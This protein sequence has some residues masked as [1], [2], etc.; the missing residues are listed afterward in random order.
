VLNRI[1]KPT[2]ALRQARQAWRPSAPRFTPEEVAAVLKQ[3]AFT[4]QAA[5]R[6]LTGGNSSNIALE[7]TA[8]RVVLKRYIWPWPHAITEHTV[9]QRARERQLPVP[10]LH[11]NQAGHTYTTVNGKTY[12]VFDFVDGFALSNFWLWP[13]ERAQRV[14][15]A[16][17]LLVQFHLAM[18]GFNPPSEKTD[19]FTPDGQRLVRDLSWHLDLVEQFEARAR[20]Q[21]QRDDLEDFLLKLA[22]PLK[23][24]LVQV[25]R[26]YALP[27]SQVPRSAIHA[28]FA[29]KNVLFNESGVAAILDFGDAC[30]NLRMLDVGRAVA[31]FA[32][33]AISEVDPHL[34]TIFLQAYSAHS[35]LTETEILNLPTG[36]RWRQLRNIVW[37][38]DRLWNQPARTRR[39]E[40]LAFVAARWE[41]SEWLRVCGERL[42]THWLAQLQSKVLLHQSA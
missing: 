1:P 22:A 25:A 42:V 2:Y 8:G 19:G 39:E 28:D 20:A 13:L 24:Q 7:T 36:M 27:V 18:E 12:A 21:A 15:Q 32:N 14:G 3:Y 6:A 16:G 41:E 26:I 38:I 10:R 37:M 30:M 17:A 34:S 29:P 35:P 11:L 31:T 5:P 40:L 23:E 33:R 9:L 4:A